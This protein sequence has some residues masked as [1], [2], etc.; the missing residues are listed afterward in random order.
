MSFVTSEPEFLSSAS[1]NLAGIG[2]T[3][4]SGT[5][6]AAAPTTGVVP[7]ASDI[8]SALT[9]QQFAAH[10][11]LYQMMCQ[12]AHVIHQQIAATLGTNSSAYETAEAA[13]AAASA[14]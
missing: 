3:M 2:N 14:V 11:Q 13:N 8:V 7:P 1:G 12:Q 6:A 5:E 9:A 10:A 4:A